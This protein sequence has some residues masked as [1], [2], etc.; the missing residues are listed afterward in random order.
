MGVWDPG[1]TNHN[2]ERILSQPCSKE[3]E[4]LSDASTVLD[5]G[6]RVLGI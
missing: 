6:F 3:V 1:K 5:L 4:I 2:L